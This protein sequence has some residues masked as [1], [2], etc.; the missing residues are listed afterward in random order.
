MPGGGAY[1][2]L[3]TEGSNT[4]ADSASSSSLAAPAVLLEGTLAKKK[5]RSAGWRPVHV[6]LRA[7]QL[8][9]FSDSTRTTLRGTLALMDVLNIREGFTH[10][11]WPSALRS[12][13]GSPAEA[14]F[15]IQLKGGRVFFFVAAS[16]ADQARWLKTLDSAHKRLLAMGGI[17][18]VGGAS[19]QLADGGVG[20]ASHGDG[21]PD[22]HDLPPSYS[23]SVAHD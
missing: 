22:A 23:E 8:E 5:K 7:T 9:Y 12:C 21:A 11:P 2:T 15:A 16:P 19:S 1:P 20:G 4:A 10:D 18:S 14:G 17:S 13:R 6:V 3:E